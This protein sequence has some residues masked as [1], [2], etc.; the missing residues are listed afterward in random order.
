MFVEKKHTI[1]FRNEIPDPHQL[2]EY[3]E[4]AVDR[5]EITMPDYKIRCFKTSEIQSRFGHKQDVEFLTIKVEAN[6]FRTVAKKMAPVLNYL[7]MLDYG[8]QSGQRFYID[9]S[10]MSIEIPKMEVIITAKDIFRADYP[11][12][13]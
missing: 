6:S 8:L 5:F 7:A 10:A 11:T 4:D 13:A 3:L 1:I 12:L 2:Q 9:D